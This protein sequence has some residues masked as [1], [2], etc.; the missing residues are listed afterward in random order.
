MSE[1]NVDVMERHLRTVLERERHDALVYTVL[2]VLATPVFV[3]LAGGTVMV[4]TSVLFLFG[5]HSLLDFNAVAFYTTANFFLAYMI[6]F[7]LVRSSRSPDEFEFDKWWIAGVILFMLLLVL[8]YGTPF[9]QG[10]PGGFGV[11]YA[12][13]GLVILGLIGQVKLPSDV[14][15]IPEG[16]HVFLVFIL[17]ISGFVVAAYGQIG[18]GS[19]LWRPPKDDEIKVGAWLL[20]Q[21]AADPDTALSAE[22]MHGPIVEILICLKLIGI[23]EAGA[24]LTPEGLEFIR[25]ATGVRQ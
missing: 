4:V 19:W 14:T 6:V 21:M 25:T 11:V 10:R 12:V 17:A 7:V 13:F 8:T 16:D 20:R 3:T 22:A 2:I 23:T 18:R 5:G 15:E 9:P 24:A 1:T